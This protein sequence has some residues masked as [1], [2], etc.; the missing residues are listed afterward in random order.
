MKCTKKK[1]LQQINEVSMISIEKRGGFLCTSH[2]KLEI[3][4]KIH[5]NASKIEHTSG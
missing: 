5:N 3:V 1:L 2:E 4:L